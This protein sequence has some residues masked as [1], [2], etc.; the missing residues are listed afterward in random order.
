MQQTGHH[1]SDELH[2]IG[3]EIHQDPSRDDDID[4][5]VRLVAGEREAWD[6]FIGDYG[7]IVRARVA[8]AAAMFGR[9]RDESAIDDAVAEVFAALL[10]SDAAALRAYAGRSSLKTYVA[11]I[12]T[13]SAMRTF[14]KMDHKSVCSQHDSGAVNQDVAVEPL[15]ANDPFTE[16]IKAEDQKRLRS[17]IDRLPEKQRQLVLGYYFQSHRYSELSERLQIPIGSIGVTLR[18]AEEKLRNWLSEKPN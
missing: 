7:R 9:Q 13:R 5:T 8:D 6:V 11:V 17:L 14:P 10:Q 12:A 15:A 4:L 3:L 2:E 18:R 1:H 16:L